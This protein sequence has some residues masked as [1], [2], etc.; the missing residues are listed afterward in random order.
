MSEL[1]HM[2]YFKTSGVLGKISAQYLY[3]VL[4]FPFYLLSNLLKS[5]LNFGF[6]IQVENYYL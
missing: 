4:L 5:M 6:V 2:I 3:E 1:C